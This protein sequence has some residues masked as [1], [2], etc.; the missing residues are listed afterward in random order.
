[1]AEG[2]GVEPRQLL[3]RHASQSSLDESSQKIGGKVRIREM[4]NIQVEVL[5]SGILSL[6]TERGRCRTSQVQDYRVQEY[7][8]PS[9]LSFKCNVLRESRSVDSQNI[10]CATLKRR[11]SWVISKYLW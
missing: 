2:A 7:R 1:V 3:L 11:G 9:S 6:S 5:P 8:L 4:E 10:P